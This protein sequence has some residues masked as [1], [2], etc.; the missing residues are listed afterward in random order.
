MK[1]KVNTLLFVDCLLWW[2][3]GWIR[4]RDRSRFVW[5]RNEGVCW[6]IHYHLNLNYVYTALA[7]TDRLLH[8]AQ[9][10]CVSV[11][12]WERERGS[13]REYIFLVLSM[14]VSMYRGSGI[15]IRLL[16]F[17]P[18]WLCMYCIVC[19]I[20]LLYLYLL[21]CVLRIEQVIEWVACCRLTTYIAKCI[22]C[23]VINVCYC[24]RLEMCKLFCLWCRMLSLL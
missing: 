2:T 12:E 7:C 19:C 23:D 20:V 16:S 24:K 13:E 1:Q 3:I 17:S 11:W 18:R 15:T 22:A 6:H 5:G 4:R 21:V 8:W 10:E 14:W 9:A